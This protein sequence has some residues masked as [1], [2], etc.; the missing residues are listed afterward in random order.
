M[1]NSLFFQHMYRKGNGKQNMSSQSQIMI[2][3]EKAKDQNVLRI[4]PG[5]FSTSQT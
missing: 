4:C 5:E 2:L 3:E 1:L